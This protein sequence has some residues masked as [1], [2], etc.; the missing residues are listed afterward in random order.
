MKFIYKTA[1]MCFVTITQHNWL[2]LGQ[3]I[4]LFKSSFRTVSNYK[5]PDFTLDIGNI[6]HYLYDITEFRYKG[7]YTNGLEVLG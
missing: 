4:L 7:C 5:M 2:F 1:K 6:V 3:K